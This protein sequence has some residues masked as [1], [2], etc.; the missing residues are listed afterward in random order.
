MQRLDEWMRLREQLPSLE[1]RFVVDD[2][3]LAN[4]LVD[5][6]DE[7]NGLLKLFDGYLTLLEVIDRAGMPDLR[8]LEVIS[9]LYF[10]GILTEMLAEGAPR[11]EWN[12]QETAPYAQLSRSEVARRARQFLSEKRG[13]DKP[14]EPEDA[15]EE[16]PPLPA[17][18]LLPEPVLPPG[19]Q[20]RTNPGQPAVKP[21]ADSQVGGKRKRR[22]LLPTR[23]YADS[24]PPELDEVIAEA[25]QKGQPSEPSLSTEE[26]REATQEFR[27]KRTTPVI[28]PGLMTEDAQTAPAPT[29]PQRTTDRMQMRPMVTP[30]HQE[31]AFSPTERVP[32]ASIPDPEAR[33]RDPLQ[34]T[35]KMQTLPPPEASP[36]P[37]VARLEPMMGPATP[38]KAVESL[39]APTAEPA[40]A[41]ESLPAPTAEPAKAVERPPPAT[42]PVKAAELPLAERVHVYATDPMDTTN[43]TN[44][45]SVP[46]SVQAAQVVTVL[47]A[48]IV[49]AAQV[50]T[51]MPAR[52]V[53]SEPGRT[54]DIVRG[55]ISVP[56]P[57]PEDDVLAEVDQLLGGDMTPT[58]LL[59][60]TPTALLGA[61]EPNTDF[62]EAVT[63][64]PPTP[65]F[66]D[67]VTL[68][69]PV[70]SARSSQSF[71]RARPL[72]PAAPRPRPAG[73]TAHRERRF[74]FE[75]NDHRWVARV[76]FFL[77]VILGTLV[78]ITLNER[79]KVERRAAVPPTP[80]P[81][82]APT[83][84]PIEDVTP[85]VVVEPDPP[86]IR[87][88]AAERVE[89]AT[90]LAARGRA[91]E[92]VTLL[93]PLKPQQLGNALVLRA[94]LYYQLERNQDALKDVNVSLR[95]SAAQPEMWLLKGRIHS[96]LHDPKAARIAFE[97]Y[98]VLRPEARN[99]ASI[100]RVLSTL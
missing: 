51:P 59:V 37:E 63:L 69:P 49:E 72:P 7:T 26:A 81:V 31:P 10:E 48:K 52:I 38:A 35:A 60:G 22:Q 20:R 96:D 86:Q 54:S 85:P 90:M 47:P 75:P 77:A 1:A 93:E 33:P 11:D 9:K 95:E 87:M 61:M 71:P 5:L 78:V 45:T 13:P 89:K 82:A 74:T 44:T 36:A 17:A 58:P 53:A 73:T 64:P 83:H 70:K 67:M 97:S 3:E 68:P 41:V 28:F 18:T 100:Q 66:D 55:Q 12:D 76:G 91:E 88:S 6:P 23:P 98:L 19:Q 84:A 42:E 62:D 79:S 40:K 56:V 30:A 34:P 29:D 2:V 16:T 15:S 39:P 94:Q 65:D 27:P 99:A 50:V 46:K 25:R 24:K 43:T 8:C 4:R 14:L 32:A 92:A 80:A 21:R 57:V